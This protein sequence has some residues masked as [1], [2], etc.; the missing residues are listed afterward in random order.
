MDH[1]LLT[2][3]SSF[4]VSNTKQLTNDKIVHEKLLTFEPKPAKHETLSDLFRNIKKEQLL[5]R[6]DCSEDKEGKVTARTE[7]T[8]ARQVLDEQNKAKIERSQSVVDFFK[9][10]A[11]VKLQESEVNSESSCD[12]VSDSEQSAAMGDKLTPRKDL[13]SLFGDDEDSEAEKEVENKNSEKDRDLFEMTNK[14]D[15]SKK[16]NSKDRDSK[17]KHREKERSSHRHKEGYHRHRDKH[18]EDKKRRKSSDREEDRKRKKDDDKSRDLPCPNENN[19]KDIDMLTEQTVT[20]EDRTQNEVTHSHKD[21]NNTDMLQESERQVT[22]PE[23]KEMA[24]RI[25]AVRV[26]RQNG[27]GSRRQRLKK[28]EVGGLVVKL[29]TPAYVERRFESRDTFKTLARNISHAL[30]D[31]GERVLT[32]SSLQIFIVF[33]CTQLCQY[34][35]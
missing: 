8:T 12:K 15:S 18:E 31:K 34:F 10:S 25:E 17:E 24:Q 22:R 26:E 6:N 14:A 32:F 3:L 13:K 4:Q 21:N 20:Q 23:V 19:E 7:F 11:S 33:Y 28:T 30:V 29:L 16:Y 2:H 5:Q 35:K 1:V 9:K 27:E